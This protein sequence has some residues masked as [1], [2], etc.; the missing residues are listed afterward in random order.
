MTGVALDMAQVL[1]R[2]VFFR[3]LGSIDPCGWMTSP[4]TAL[5]FFGGLGLRLMSGSGGAVRLSLVFVFG[6]LVLGLPVSVLL[7]FWLTGDG[8]LGT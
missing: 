7:V 5:V 3:Y 8:P 2:F 6:D 1:G 4:T